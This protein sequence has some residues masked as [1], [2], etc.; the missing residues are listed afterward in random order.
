MVPPHRDFTQVKP[1]PNTP[2]E[3]SIRRYKEEEKENNRYRVDFECRYVLMV[4]V[5]AS[6]KRD[7]LIYSLHFCIVYVNL[8]HLTI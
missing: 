7:T 5:N 8:F 6:T 4:R 1:E 2:E 3:D